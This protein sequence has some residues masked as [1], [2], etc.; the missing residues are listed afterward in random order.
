MLNTYYFV[1]NNFLIISLSHYYQSIVLIFKKYM[2]WGDVHTLTDSHFTKGKGI[3]KKRRG[4]VLPLLGIGVSA[5]KELSYCGECPLVVGVG[6]T[7]LPPQEE[8]CRI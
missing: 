1:I 6:M 7:S 8:N 4:D 3:C 2:F 5:Q